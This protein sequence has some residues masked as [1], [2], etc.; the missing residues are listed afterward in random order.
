LIAITY[1]PASTA[2]TAEIACASQTVAE[3]PLR[4]HYVPGVEA[5]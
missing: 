4:A 1:T 3:E 2:T 5:Y